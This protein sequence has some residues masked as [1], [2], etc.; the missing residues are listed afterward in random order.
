MT[1]L[2]RL[3]AV[4]LLLA[5]CGAM[6]A[7]FGKDSP[8]PANGRL[9]APP[10]ETM[11]KAG[12][13]A[14]NDLDLETLNGPRSVPPAS[15]AAV[16]AQGAETPV[17]NAPAQDSE[18]GAQKPAQPVKQVSIAA[19][20]VLPV[21]GDSAKGNQQLTAAMRETLK[22]AGWPVRSKK[23]SDTLVVA[24]RVRIGEPRGNVQTVTL[25]WEVS[26]PSG[27]SLGLISQTNDVPTG[28]LEGGWGDNATAVVEAAATGIFKLIDKLR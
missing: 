27:K 12:P 5:G 2:L 4:C 9:V 14:V 25:A 11:V 1:W 24:G 23:G 15:T 10:W 19:V 21:T 6:P 17:A 26:D 8:V 16:E 28:S 13:G 22:T 18:T 7:P 20:A 3:M